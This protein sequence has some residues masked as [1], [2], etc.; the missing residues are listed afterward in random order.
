MERGVKLMLGYQRGSGAL[1]VAV[2][3][4]LTMSQAQAANIIT[5]DN[6]A[7]SC[8][9]STLCSTN[10]TTGYSGTNAFDVTTI[11]QWFQYDGVD[12]LS[13]IAGQV[14]QDNGAASFLVTNNTGSTLT[15]LSLTLTDIFNAAASPPVNFQAGKGAGGTG[16]SFEAL[17]G[18]DFVSC[19][20]GAAGNGFPC[21]STAGQAAA[22]FSA[23]TVTYT[24]GGYSIA[25]GADFLI[26]LASF[27]TEGANSTDIFP[28][29]TPVPEPFTLSLFGAG[30]AGVA[31]LRRRKKKAT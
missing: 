28:T 22:N 20:N 16:T 19:T 23:G 25:S 5:F 30:L 2:A 17:S 3:A 1:V 15:G 29:P 6:N 13:H 9:G 12:G 24:F 11:N 4:A 21:Y 18:P 27:D 31:A 26:T 8:G 10:G 7:T 14:A